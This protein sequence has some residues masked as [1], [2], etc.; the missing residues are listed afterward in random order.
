LT[1]AIM[2]LS[3]LPGKPEDNTGTRAAGREFRGRVSRPKEADSI[4]EPF[5]AGNPAPTVRPSAN[6][7]ASDAIVGADAHIRPAGKVA[8][9]RSFPANSRPVHGQPGTAVPTANPD[10]LRKRS[11]HERRGRVSRP[12]EADSISEPSPAAA[13]DDPPAGSGLRAV[14]SQPITDVNNTR[15]SSS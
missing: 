9:Y 6:A 1:A 5:R 15:R 14:P 2:R 7:T 10:A 3:C 11:Q 13:P 4:S 12:K 8:V